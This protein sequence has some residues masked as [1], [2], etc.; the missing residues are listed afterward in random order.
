MR[1]DGCLS[2]AI[3]E[4][5]QTVRRIEDTHWRD[6][7]GCST[8][9]MRR[10][11]PSRIAGLVK[12]PQ[13]LNADVYALRTT[14]HFTT[15][16]LMRHLP[17]GDDRSCNRDSPLGVV[18]GFADPPLTFRIAC[19]SGDDCIRSSFEAPDA[20][21]IPT[22]HVL[23]RQRLCLL[24]DG[25]TGGDAFE[26]AH[27]AIGDRDGH[28]GQMDRSCAGPRLCRQLPEAAPKARKVA[29]RFLAPPSRLIDD[30]CRKHQLQISRRDS[31]R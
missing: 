3:Y 5:V 12:F 7:N 25:I 31:V 22:E 21:R 17:L 1:G 26:A 18:R 23:A 16:G 4:L 27:D 30:G 6:T 19:V 28:I 20:L 8:A 11:D 15:D 29:T 10:R 14:E 2:S 9:V 13:R 24:A